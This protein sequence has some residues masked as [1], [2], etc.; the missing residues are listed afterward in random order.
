MTNFSTLLKSEILR[1][2]RKET[3]SVAEDLKK[4]VASQRAEIAKL[5]RRCD[6]LEKSSKALARSIAR[7]RQDAGNAN[8]ASDGPALRFRAAGMAKNRAR[9]GLGAAEF[10]RL[11]GTTAQ[12]IYSWERGQSKPTGENLRAIAALRSLGKREV[13]ARLAD[14]PD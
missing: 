11:I 8:S 14:S 4:T 3:R 1:L 9:L 2:A 5:K 7:S 6:E 10:G 13:M 12:T